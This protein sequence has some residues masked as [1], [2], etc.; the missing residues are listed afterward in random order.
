[1]GSDKAFLLLEGRTFISSIASEMSKVSDDVMVMIGKKSREEFEDALGPDVRVYPD[2]QYLGNPIGG[3]ASA[4]P[5]VRHR[6]AAVVACDSPLVKA[7]VIEYLFTA[8]GQHSAAV[9]VWDEEDRMTMEPLCAVYDVAEAREAIAKAIGEGNET[10]KR[11]VL[12]LQDVLYV[13]VS[14]LRL[15]DQRLDSLMNVNTPTEYEALEDR[16]SSSTSDWQGFSRE[17]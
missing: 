11:M 17:V 9:P 15:V 12:H 3:I 8:L 7:E 1:M 4:F 6:H 2:D 16:M 13:D 5:H 14:Q 10:P